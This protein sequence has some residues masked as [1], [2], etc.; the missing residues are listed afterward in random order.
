MTPEQQL[1]YLQLENEQVKRDAAALRKKLAETSA[2]ARRVERAYQ[3]A[4]LLAT[5]YA[6]GIAP[7]RRFAALHGMTQR[8]WQNA[9]GLLR[10]GRI[11]NRSR[12]WTTT[13]LATIERRLERSRQQ[14]IETP[15]AYQARLNRHARHE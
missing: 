8:R 5:W 3:D 11:L 13:D 12:H 10:M 14:A 6:G 9:C 15:E 4:L 2:H 7:S 1:R